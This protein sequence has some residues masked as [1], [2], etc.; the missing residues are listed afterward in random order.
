MPSARGPRPRGVFTTRS[1]LPDEIRS[2][3]STPDRS[4]PTFATTVSTGI[5]L[6]LEHRGGARGRRDREPELGEPAGGDEPG[7]LVAVGERQEHRALAAAACSPRR[8]GSCANAMPKV[9]SMPMT[10]PVERISG[11]SSVSTSGKRLNGSTASLIDDVVRLRRA[12]ASRPFGAQL[13][14]RRAEHRPRRDLRERHAGRLAHERHRA[15]RARVRLDDEHLAVLHRVLHV[16]Q[17]DD[18]ERAG[19]R[20]RVL[21]DRLRAPGAASVGGGIAHAESPE[22]T[23]ASSMCSII[24][25]MTHVAGAVA[26]R[27]D[28]DFDRVFEEAVD[29]RGP[30]RRQPAFA[31]ERAGRARAR[32]SRGAGRCRRRRSPSRARRARTTGRTST[33]YPIAVRD[34]DRCRPRRSRCRRRLRDAEPL[35]QRVELLAVLGRVDRRRD[36]CRGSGCRL[37]SSACASF[38]GVCPPSAT[39]TPRELPRAVERPAARRRR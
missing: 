24:P 26:Q 33:G 5:P 13:G 36:S 6:A 34:R 25:P 18:V 9:R 22:C 7:L 16:E 1:T 4:S 39:I 12:A 3:A 17:A 35:A 32:P 31:A 30:F 38:S 27:V 14:E 11:P 37:A 28:V 8:P 2:T 29:E 21:F 20:A 23:P 15:A 10:S 19:E